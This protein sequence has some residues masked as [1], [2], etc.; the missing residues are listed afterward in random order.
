MAVELRNMQW[1]VPSGAGGDRVSP[2]VQA[3]IR[4]MLYYS[5]T[6]HTGDRL[7]ASWLAR[8]ALRLHS[9]S[10]TQHLDTLSR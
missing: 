10:R 3:W 7:M 9:A 4:E 2:E 5:P 1:V 6:A 8:E